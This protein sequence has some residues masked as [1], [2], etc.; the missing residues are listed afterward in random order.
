MASLAI[1]NYKLVNM[2]RIGM[3]RPPVSGKA[4]A[5]PGRDTIRSEKLEKMAGKG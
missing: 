3:D 2:C 4:D 1:I 5:C